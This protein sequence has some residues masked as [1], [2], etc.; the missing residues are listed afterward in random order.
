VR[1]GWAPSSLSRLELSRFDE[2]IERTALG[3]QTNKVAVAH[4]FASGPPPLESGHTCRKLVPDIRASEIAP[5]CVRLEP[6]ALGGPAAF[7][8]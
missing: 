4:P 5:Y 3:M 7:A 8:I 1:F 2:K 6:I